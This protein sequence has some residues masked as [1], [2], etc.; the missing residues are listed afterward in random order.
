MLSF[1]LAGV[2]V[3]MGFA[4]IKAVELRK[5]GGRLFLHRW[6]R[7]DVPESFDNEQELVRALK[8]LWLRG[9]FSSRRLVVALPSQQV[10]VRRVDLPLMSPQNLVKAACYKALEVLPLPL[11][12]ML[13]DVCGFVYKPKQVE[14]TVVAAR[15]RYV[16]EYL[17][18]FHQ[19]G[20]QVVALE[21]SAL[22]LQRLFFRQQAGETIL[23]EAKREAIIISFFQGGC[24]RD[25]RVLNI[26]MGLR[27]EG[28]DFWL[29]EIGDYLQGEM[30]RAQ[31]DWQGGLTEEGSGDSLI[32][33]AGGSDK[34]A[35]VLSGLFPSRLVRMDLQDY[36]NLKSH[37]CHPL[38]P[39]FGE[40]L[41]AF[42][43]AAR[44]KDIGIRGLKEIGAN[45][46]PRRSV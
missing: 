2:G 22:A 17:D 19:A 41:T 38:P 44:P 5:R 39:E 30:A 36:I 33:L 32:V 26:G 10:L 7:V 12:E 3:D 43:L 29:R 11:E 21:L 27:A 25:M 1:P 23:L 45:F 18:L 13:V 24:L 31:R 46:G 15:R 16:E 42:G 14:A 35:Q 9:R 20:L 28:E 6:D 40:Y 8:E 4:A 37:R 34:L